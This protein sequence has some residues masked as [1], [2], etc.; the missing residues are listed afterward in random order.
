MDIYPISI[1]SRH[2]IRPLITAGTGRE[3]FKF[4]LFVFSH[5]TIS[6]PIKGVIKTIKYDIY[7]V[8]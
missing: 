4:I 8:F 1:A 7:F 6:G 2:G 3:I 5:F